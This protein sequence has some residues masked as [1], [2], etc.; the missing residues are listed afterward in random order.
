MF[1]MLDIR[2]VS[3]WVPLHRGKRGPDHMLAKTW[4]HIYSKKETLSLIDS[5]NFSTFCCACEA[6]GVKKDQNLHFHSNL[7]RPTK[8]SQTI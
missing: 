2:K 1:C 8:K 6:N 4:T 7:F 5:G 3:F